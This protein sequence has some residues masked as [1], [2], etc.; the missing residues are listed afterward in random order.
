L[1]GQDVLEL[2]QTAAYWSLAYVTD[3][4]MESGTLFTAPFLTNVGLSMMVKAP[5]APMNTL[6]F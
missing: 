3:S 6:L 4:R 1:G 5:G 2:K